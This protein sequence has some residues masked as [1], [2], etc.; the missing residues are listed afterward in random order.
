MRR[1]LLAALSVF[2]T[3]AVLAFA[4]PLC[5]IAATSRT[6]QLVLGRSGDADW[7]AT[8][9]GAATTTGDNRALAM[10]IDRYHQLYGE[11]VLVVDA[12]GAP[13]ADAGVDPDADAVQAV[14]AA[15]RRNQPPAPVAQLMPWSPATVVIARPMGSGV[16][17]DGAVVIEASTADARGDIVRTWGIVTAG[18]LAAMVLF[19]T[20][21][22]G[23]SR[24]VLR[25]LA[26]LSTAVAALTA[27]L[28][29]PRGSART[30]IT[31]RHG[32]PAEIRAVAVAFD[33]MA[34]AVA[35]ATAAQRQLVADTAHAMRN[36]LAALIIR[37]DSLEPAVP[38]G[39]AATFRGATAEAER[40][41]GLLD[42]LLTLAVAEG[43]TDFDPAAPVTASACDAAAVAA[44]RI[45][46]WHTAFEHAGLTLTAEIGAT[47]METAVPADILA[48]ILDVA[49]SNACR[50]AGAGAAAV[51][52][53]R[54]DGDRVALAVTD[55][56]AGVPAGELHRLTTRFYR[57]SAAGTGG[58]GLGLPIAAA[59]VNARRGTLRVEHVVPHGLSM[60]V[61]FPA[62][63]GPAL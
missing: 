45:D 56:G 48:Q 6:Q 62:A 37:L 40:L 8:L 23:L 33:A 61:E 1:R 16:Q 26:E 36:P 7:F 43:D 63:P 47:P 25:P 10:E 29:S 5:L 12:R 46:A 44:D 4:V 53:V 32:G 35:D 60:V 41:T 39:S 50:Y 9:A 57:G 42:G 20:L 34:V 52:R 55:T 14:L 22:L 15:V 11:D 17:V 31:R 59:L 2:A 58:S 21:A 51:L 30:A 38:A 24:W 19:T 3:I 28:P 13:I 49:L 54:R 18:A 27:T